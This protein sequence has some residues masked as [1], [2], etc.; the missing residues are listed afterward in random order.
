MGYERSHRRRRFHWIISIE[1]A[2]AQCYD[3]CS[4][5]TGVRNGVAAIIKQ[6]NPKCLLIHCYCHTLNLAVGDTVKSIPLLKETLEDSYELT[7]LVKYLPKRQAALKNIQEGL[8]IENL[9]LPVDDNNTDIDTFSGLR[10][11]CPT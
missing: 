1:D 7:K 8:K 5:M 9:K 10:L 6:D 2:K 4:T 3:G 11:F